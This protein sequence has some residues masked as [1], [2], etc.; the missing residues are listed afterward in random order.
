LNAL[1]AAV[2]PVAAELATVLAAILNWSR[3]CAGMSL[4]TIPSHEHT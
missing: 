3:D 4:Q 2:S 1:R